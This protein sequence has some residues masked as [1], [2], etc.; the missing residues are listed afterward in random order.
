MR[1][2]SKFI[3]VRKYSENKSII[4]HLGE[5]EIKIFAPVVCRVTW[6]GLRDRRM[7]EIL[8][9]DQDQQGS[10]LQISSI[11][12]FLLTEIIRFLSRKILSIIFSGLV[13]AVL[14]H[15]TGVR[16]YF[17]NRLEDRAQPKVS[18]VQLSSLYLLYKLDSKKQ[19]ND[20]HSVSLRVMRRHGTKLSLLLRTSHLN[21]P[22]L[23]VSHLA[24]D[25]KKLHV[26]YQ[27]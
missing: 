14:H 21:Y 4:I 7:S 3:F 25:E 5:N 9:E 26:S 1:L 13:L 16:K 8:S 23:A 20:F 6:Q 2:C 19:T 17:L 27:G 24:S 12:V 18:S 22:L 11:R 10:D 15:D